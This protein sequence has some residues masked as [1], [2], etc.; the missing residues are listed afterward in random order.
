MSTSDRSSTPA[1]DQAVDALFTLFY[2]GLKRAA[3]RANSANGQV[4]IDTTMLVHEAY[5]KLRNRS[6]L[7]FESEAKF[8]A[9]AARVMRSVLLDS[10]R[11][12]LRTK[13]DAGQH[14]LS[15]DITD[16]DA[17]MLDSQMA[18]QRSAQEVLALDDALEQLC[19]DD[20]RAAEV[21]E[22]HY[23]AGLSFDQIAP[24]KNLSVRT[25]QRDWEFARAFLY[26]ALAENAL[27][28]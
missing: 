25:V 17:R 23:F 10:A 4:G 15:L 28:D 5:L 12:R 3:H 16:I 8:Y 14:A 21:V 26:A 1:A 27:A 13:R 24:L 22:L 7:D 2:D 20:A 6:D 9:Y 11:M 18:L 19:A